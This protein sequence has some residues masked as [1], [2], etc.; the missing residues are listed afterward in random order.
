MYEVLIK[1]C[2]YQC[3]ARLQIPIG[4]VQLEEDGV[5]SLFSK[6]HKNFPLIKLNNIGLLY[7]YNWLAMIIDLPGAA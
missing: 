3:E 1:Q 2:V 5:P 4:L 6:K 7:L